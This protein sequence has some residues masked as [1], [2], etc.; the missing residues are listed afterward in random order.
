MDRSA[1]ASA[2]RLLNDGTWRSLGSGELSSHSRSAACR[3]SHSSFELGFQ[4]RN[5]SIVS[6]LSAGCRCRSDTGVRHGM[7]SCWDEHEE[8]RGP[9][10]V[11]TRRR[12]C[13]RAALYCDWF[14]P[15]R[16]PEKRTRATSTSMSSYRRCMSRS[17]RRA[18]R[19]RGRSKD[20]PSDIDRSR[21]PRAR[22]SSADAGI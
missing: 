2:Q 5:T 10:A 16:H 22:K 18:R 19:R 3:Q 13:P 9:Q 12:L 15:Q 14:A 21:T 11:A 4:Q 7:H 17:A 6:Q 20:P 1:F 8:R